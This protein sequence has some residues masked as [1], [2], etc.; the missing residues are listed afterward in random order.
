MYPQI[1]I[2]KLEAQYDFIV[3]G[4]G[5]AGCVLARRL[6]E[7]GKHTVLLIE[8]GDS[9][10]SWLNKT[11]LTSLHHWSTGK[12]STVF[13]SVFDDKFGRSFPLITGIGLG[14]CTRINGG[15]YTCGVPAE[16]NAWSEEGRPG[17]GYTDLKPYFTK[18]ENW[19]G[20]VPEEWHGSNG[21]LTVQSFKDYF[22]GCSKEAANAATDLGFHSI[23][24]MHSPLEPSIGWIKMQYA[25]A[26]DGSRHSSFYKS[27]HELLP[28]S[29][30]SLDRLMVDCAQTLLKFTSGVGPEEHLEKMGIEVI[31]NTPG[32]GTHLQDHIF[33]RTSYHCPL[34]D[35]LWA[36]ILKPWKLIA[37][38]FKYLWRGTGWFLCTSAEVE[39]FGMSSLIDAD[40]EPKAAS[41]QDK[42]PFNPDNRPDF[43]VMATNMADPMSPGITN[44]FKGL[45]GTNSV[46]LKA[47]SRGQVRLRSRDPLQNPL[48]EMRYLTHPKDWSALRTALRVSVQLGR[49]MRANGYALE[50]VEAPRTLDDETLD[51]YIRERVETMY[52]YASSCRMAEETDALPGVVDPELRVHGVPNLR[53]SDSSILPSAPAAHPQALVYAVAEKCADMM[54]KE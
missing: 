7:G 29:S 17:W 43:A 49:Q 13:D 54:L 10:D 36:L 28:P 4:G 20:P 25:I 34:A 2:D 44:R 41:A 22:F 23:F 46:L 8:K 48:C 27:A 16:Y 50:D 1:S 6:S 53:I 5:N 35:S 31:R 38:L 14:G 12:H 40:G 47:E 42:D 32:V 51:A 26:A 21:P 11:P 18:S 33:V 45:F 9:E 24:D 19:L 30:R 37:E 52:H 15:Q 3:V 39:I